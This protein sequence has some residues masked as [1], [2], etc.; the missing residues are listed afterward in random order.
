MIVIEN[1]DLRAEIVEN[2]SKDGHFNVAFRDIDSGRVL[3]VVN[4][5]QSLESAKAYAK[6]VLG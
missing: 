2:T 1:E 4:I 3:P 5:F 6:E